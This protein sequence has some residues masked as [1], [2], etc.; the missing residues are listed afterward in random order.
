M[1]NKE[2]KDV[3]DPKPAEAPRVLTSEQR[4]LLRANSAIALVHDRKLADLVKSM[5]TINERINNQSDHLCRT[6]DAAV[7]RVEA[8]QFKLDSRITVLEQALIAAVERDREL[9]VE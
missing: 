7:E 3:V 4:M 9:E 1:E 5:W 6:L 8:A 2:T